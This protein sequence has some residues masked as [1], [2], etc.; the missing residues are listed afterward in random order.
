MRV[1]H[2]IST[3]IPAYSRGGPVQAVHE[4]CKT[5]LE[6]GLDITVFTTNLDL[7]K[8]SGIPINEPYY[9]E[10]VKVF[11][12]PIVKHMKFC[13]YSKKLSRAIKRRVKSFD[14]VHIHSV[15]LYPGWAAAYWCRKYKVPYILNTCGTID[16]KMI[17]LKG[18]LKKMLCINLIERRNINCSSAIHVTSLAEKKGL[19]VF[20]FK[21]SA[22]IIPRSVDPNYYRD[23]KKRDFLTKKYPE[24]LNKKIVLFLGRIHKK[25][26]FDLLASAFE[27][28]IDTRKDVYLVIAGPGE[29]GYPDKIKRLFEK[30]GIIKKV[31]FTGMLLGEEKLSAFYDSD[32]FVLPSYGENFGIA[33]LEAMACGLPVVI[34]SR[35]GLYP[36][37]EKYKAGIITE[38]D[39]DQI[40]D[41]ILTLLDDGNMRNLMGKNGKRLVE[42]KFTSDKVADMVIDM[43]RSVSNRRSG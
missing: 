36:D 2:V 39:S 22:E 27:K 16:P 43:Y 12:F 37:V 11:Y 9:V 41:A 19:E 28:V 3:Y 38:C 7:K 15:Y 24:L 32:I 20:K 18:F 33:V 26:G 8:E 40:A 5:L 21:T 4:L 13:C 42:D 1:L 35:V 31:I 14:I 23:S 34:T 30:C 17:R 6:K 10:G 25:K 29:E